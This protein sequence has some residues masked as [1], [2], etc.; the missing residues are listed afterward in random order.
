MGERLGV[1]GGT[2]DPPH[3]AHAIVVQDVFE[4]LEL[5]RLLVMPAGRPPHREPVLPA[6]VRHALVTELFRG[7]PGIEV[8]DLELR[9]PGPSYTVETLAEV[10]ARWSPEALY[11]VIGTDQLRTIRSWHR[12]RELP[13]LARIAVVRRAG[14]EAEA[15]GRACEEETE[16]PIPVVPV[17]VTRVE[18]SGTRIRARLREGRSI[19]YLVPEC[20]RERVK[21]AWAEHGSAR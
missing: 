4:R 19:R 13:E 11:C 21:A 8:S 9:R 3:V 14:E 1:F 15:E 18:L 5:D 7:V 6:P 17:A 20:I 12:H 16:S 2:F 10:R